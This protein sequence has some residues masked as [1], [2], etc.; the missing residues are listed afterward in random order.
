MIKLTGWCRIFLVILGYGWFLYYRR[1]VSYRALLHM[2]VNSRQM[3]LYTERGF[4]IERWEELISDARSLRREIRN[5]ADQYDVKWDETNDEAGG[6][7]VLKLLKDAEKKSK[8]NSEVDDDE[9]EED[10]VEIGKEK[11]DL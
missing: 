2:T 5:I 6:E 10:V 3:K 11:K 8:K 9:E 7:K 1:E 4:D